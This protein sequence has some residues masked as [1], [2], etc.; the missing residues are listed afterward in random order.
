MS[1]ADD[2]QAAL[3]D[4]AKNPKVVKGDVGEVQ[5]HDPKVLME[6]EKHLRESSVLSDG[7][8]FKLSKIISG[9]P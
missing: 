6:V 4:V 1:D 9:G 8:G 5:E 2:V 7:G 3:V